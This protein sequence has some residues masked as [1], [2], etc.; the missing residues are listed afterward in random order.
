MVLEPHLRS[1]DDGSNPLASPLRADNLTG[2]PPALVI[3][4][5]F[6]PLR[7]EGEAYAARL[8]AAGVPVTLQRYDGMIHGFFSLGL[9]SS[10]V[11]P[12]STP[13]RHSC[14]PLLPGKIF[15]RRTP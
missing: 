13:P 4:A 11:R 14:V 8:Q 15:G 9:S 5:E 2:L 12:P 1:A 3:T 7:D 6:D 10:R